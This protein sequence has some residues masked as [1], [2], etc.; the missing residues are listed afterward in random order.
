M[1]DEALSRLSTTSRII[2]LQVCQPLAMTPPKM[3]AAA[4]SWSTWKGCGSNCVANAMISCSLTVRVPSWISCPA[5]RHATY[6]CMA[7]WVPRSGRVVEARLGEEAYHV[8]VNV[9]QRQGEHRQEH[10]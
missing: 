10:E 2:M 4:A 5:Y 1:L 9:A 6:H 8:V 3:D 7:I